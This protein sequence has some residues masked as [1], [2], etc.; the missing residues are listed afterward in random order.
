MNPRKSHKVQIDMQ[1]FSIRGKN[2]GE[3]NEGGQILISSLIFISFVWEG[4]GLN[5]LRWGWGSWA[6]LK[7]DS[8]LEKS[9]F[10]KGWRWWGGAAEGEG[11]YA[12]EFT[13]R[14]LTSAW[15]ETPPA[16][17][18]GCGFHPCSRPARRRTWRGTQSCPR[19]KRTVGGQERE[20]S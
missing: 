18:L 13:R 14:I 3:Q 17:H 9:R 8:A 2:H 6:V 5:R 15:L 12:Y 7:D 19:P 1:W 20:L 10:G 16:P 11:I 4:S